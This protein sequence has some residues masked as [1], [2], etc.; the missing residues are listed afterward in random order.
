M[1]DSGLPAL[2]SVNVTSSGAV[3]DT[4]SA[5]NIATGGFV[6]GAGLPS[7]ITVMNPDFRSTSSPSA[8]ITLRTT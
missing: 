1:H 4:T 5:L 7:S 6:T 3:P 2:S 8:L